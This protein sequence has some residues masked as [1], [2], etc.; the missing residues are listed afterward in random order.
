MLVF[1]GYADCWGP[2][3][4]AFARRPTDSSLASRSSDANFW[5]TDGGWNVEKLLQLSNEL[6]SA[7]SQGRKLFVQELEDLN[8]V[9]DMMIV[10][11][12]DDEA[13]SQRRQPGSS[14]GGPTTLLKITFSAIQRARL[15]KLL[16]DMMVAYDKETIAAPLGGRVVETGLGS[17]IDVASTLQEHW[18]V[19][20]VIEPLLVAIQREEVNCWKDLVF[21][22]ALARY[23]SSTDSES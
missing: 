4:V 16:A 21:I 22:P 13:P 5:I 3:L 20:I 2:M 12:L 9:L 18:Y 23:A 10:D 7:L 8:F 6:R 19:L 11:K 1:D 14:A 15:D 17:E